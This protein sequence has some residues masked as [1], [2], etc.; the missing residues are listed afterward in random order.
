[1]LIP[2]APLVSILFL[3]QAL[4]AVLLR[5]ILPFIRRLAQDPAVMGDHALGLAGKLTTGMTLAV[6]ARLGCGAGS[7]ERRVNH[8]QPCGRPEPSGKPAIEHRFPW[9]AC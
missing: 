8:E 1:V 4:N 5:L 2:G 9:N 7:P 3:S 6:V